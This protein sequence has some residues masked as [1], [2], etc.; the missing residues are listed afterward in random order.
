MLRKSSLMPALPEL[1]PVPGQKHR[2]RNQNC[3][4]MKE[5]LKPSLAS[6]GEEKEECPKTNTAPSSGFP[7]LASQLQLPVPV[8]RGD[9]HQLRGPR[10]IPISESIPVFPR[11]KAPVSPPGILGRLPEVGKSGAWSGSARGAGT[12]RSVTVRGSLRSNLFRDKS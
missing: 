5:G 2:W 10:A 7:A 11:E 4:G 6:G 12:E 8:S 1:M 9:R 3:L